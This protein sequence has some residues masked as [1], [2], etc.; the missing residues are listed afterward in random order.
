MLALVVAACNGPRDIGHTCLAQMDAEDYRSAAANCERAFAM[1]GAPELGASAARAHYFLGDDDAVLALVERLGDGPKGGSVWHLAGRVYERRSQTEAARSAYRRAL[2]RHRAA[3]EHAASAVDGE[4]LSLSYWRETRYREALGYA[5]IDVE[6]A[7][8]SHDRDLEA[9]A[10]VILGDVYYEVGYAT[11]ADAEYQR[12]VALGAHSA[13]L[14]VKE[15]LVHKT[16]NRPGLARQA[17]RAA[18]AIAAADDLRTIAS[19]RLN[20]AELA[21]A[22]GNL[23]EAGADLDLARVAVEKA[24]DRPAAIEYRH[25]HALWALARAD[26]DVAM[27]DL[28]AAAAL[29]PV[30]DA[31][32]QIELTRGRVLAARGDRDGAAAAYRRSIE[33]L[34]QM[35]R[36]LALDELKVWFLP[37]RRAPYEALF[38]LEVR[39]D[40]PLEA[41]AVAE[42]ARARDFVDRFIAASRAGSRALDDAAV[43]ADDVDAARALVPAL[44]AQGDLHSRPIDGLLRALAPRHVVGY[45]QANGRL[46]LSVIER[47]DVRFRELPV[48]V[49]EVAALVDRLFVAPDDL[50]A[51]RQLGDL[52]LPADALPP[53]GSP[54]ELVLDPSLERVPFAELRVGDRWLVEDHA[55]AVVPSIATLA[56]IAERPATADVAPGVVVGDAAHDLPAAADEAVRVAARLG[57]EPHVGRDATVA[58]VRAAARSRLLHLAVHAGIAAGGP[59]LEL[60]DGAVSATQILDWRL[61]PRVVVLAGCASGAAPPGMWSSLGAAFLAAGSR[62][63]LVT[64]RSVDDAATARL[65]DR[66]YEEGGA[67]D[68][69][70][71][72]ARAQRAFART[73]P[74]SQWAFFFVIGPA[75]ATKGVTSTARRAP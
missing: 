47:G 14:A 29:D 18:L 49:R 48:S 51:A 16:Q 64:S 20:L 8:A 39:G 38:E 43:V 24:D 41:L 11:L 67:N 32:W 61:G 72:L 58:R 56:L 6:E 46:W 21:L 33:T 31:R 2:E 17:Y 44:A 63:V 65:I 10:H 35:R 36:A 54:L 4:V 13:P 25:D 62:Q 9:T 69:A 71:A 5:R 55:V 57:V 12:A 70:D 74:P 68:A 30:L 19:A 34:E 7:V 23:D 45:F 37:K 60:A 40:H 26:L 28:D 22:D 73:L 59:W 52:L 27:Q 53:R 66:F 50:A 1:S 42:R 75:A 3:G 15:G